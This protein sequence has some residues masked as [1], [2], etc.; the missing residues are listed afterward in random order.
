LQ[1]E[2]RCDAVHHRVE[3]VAVDLLWRTRRQ[4][5]TGIRGGTTPEV[6]EDQNVKR[7]IPG[8]RSGIIIQIGACVDID[9]VTGALIHGQE[10]SRWKRR[11]PRVA[12]APVE[13]WIYR[14]VMLA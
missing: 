12:E 9:G 1:V 13:F 6:S 11:G 14:R 5:C 7:G 10:A 2:R 8:Q 4:W 3:I